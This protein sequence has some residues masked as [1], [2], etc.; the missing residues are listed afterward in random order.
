MTKSIKKGRAH[1]VCGK[2]NYIKSKK[3]KFDGIMWIP[4][5]EVIKLEKREGIL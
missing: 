5:H 4:Y 1:I 3:E 2:C